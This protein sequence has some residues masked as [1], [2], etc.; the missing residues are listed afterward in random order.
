[1]RRWGWGASTSRSPPRRPCSTATSRCAAALLR[2]WYLI[3]NHLSWSTQWFFITLGGFTP[4]VYYQLTGTMILPE[5][6]ELSYV[7]GISAIP[8]FITI[9]SV[10]L[11][12]CFVP[13]IAMIILDS[14][15]RPAPPTPR[16]LINKV[17]GHACW[18]AISPITF[19]C[20]ALPALDAQ[21][22]LMLGRRME[23]RVTEKI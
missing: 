15:M 1:M 4:W 14:R 13:F 11:A 3:E 10:I 17:L 7:T 12:P 8:D 22:R 20:S 16:T 6:I 21:V 2:L 23:Y 9:G 19:F 5:W 18:L